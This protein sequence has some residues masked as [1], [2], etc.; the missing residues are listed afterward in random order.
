[1]ALPELVDHKALGRLSSP[2]LRSQRGLHDQAFS[3][4]PLDRVGD[5]CGRNEGSTLLEGCGTAVEQIRLRQTTSSVMDQNMVGLRRQSI[6]TTQHGFLAGV[7]SLNP[8]DGFL[9]VL[10]QRE[11]RGSIHLLP[12]QSD[13]GDPLCPQR[14]LK[15]PGDQRT[16]GKRQQQFV[17]IRSHTPTAA[18]G[19]DQQ[20][21]KRLLPQAGGYDLHKISSNAFGGGL[22][23]VLALSPGPLSDQL[24]RMPAIASLCRTLGASLQVACA[25]ACREAWMLL[26]ALD[27]LIPIDFDNDPALADW[28]N[29]LG[30]IREPDFQICLNFVEGRQV[31]LMLSMSRIMTRI[32]RTGFSS[33]ERVV[34][35]PGWSAQRLAPWLEPLGV[36]LDADA[37]RLTL[38]QPVL[39]Q[40]RSDHPEGDGPLLLMA[41]QEGAT[42]W[43]EE[44]WNALPSAIQTRLATLRCDRLP[45]G[46]PLIRR[47]AAVAC[48]DVV[49]TSCLITQIL[50]VFSGTP[51]VA[52]GAE[53]GLLPERSDLR[54]LG[55]A[56]ELTTLPEDEVLKALGF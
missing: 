42:D 21:H 32:G 36:S 8:H 16:A 33:T 3:I 15:G 39:D 45:A 20:M 53:P 46:L 56:S 51:L 52:L 54:C 22:M 28:A 41:P 30:S 31:N 6:E 50:T 24:V 25:P 29:L 27:K 49:L 47:A 19:G 14:R 40:V 23:R 38:P 34:D 13:P 43:P 9:G 37:F 2:E 44:H 55:T 17:A 35:G 26:P 1:M 7:T 10:N 11:N 5:G 48:A 12:D 18:G 4:H